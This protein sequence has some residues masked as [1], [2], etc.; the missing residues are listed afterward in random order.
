VAAA[1]R[2]IDATSEDGGR[3]CRQSQCMALAFSL[4]LQHINS[5][6]QSVYVQTVPGGDGLR[7]QP[8]NGADYHALLARC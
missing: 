6:L 8:L 4:K 7:W 5:S 2:R 3:P 1:A